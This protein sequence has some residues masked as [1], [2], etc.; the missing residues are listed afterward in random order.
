MGLHKTRRGVSRAS[1][2]LLVI[3]MQSASLVQ[4]STG[5][6]RGG[7][8]RDSRRERCIVYANVQGRA[9]RLRAT[10]AK[11]TDARRTIPGIGLTIPSFAFACHRKRPVARCPALSPPSEPRPWGVAKVPS[12]GPRQVTDSVASPQA[13]LSVAFVITYETC[14]ELDLA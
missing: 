2:S 12:K 13:V 8:P 5:I 10:S 14:Q 11:L 3:L 9:C 7:P 1:P 4:M 6:T